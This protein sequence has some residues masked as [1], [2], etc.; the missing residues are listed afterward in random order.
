MVECRS[1]QSHPDWFLRDEEGRRIDDGGKGEGYVFM[2]PGQ[3]EWRRFFLRRLVET[4]ERGG[5][6][7]VLLDNVDASLA[8]YQ[9]RGALPARYPDD[10][11]FQTAVREFLRY[12][13][14]TYFFPEHRPL[15]A[16]IVANRD[17]E[18][19]FRYLEFLDG[20]MDESWAV[21]WTDAYRPVEEWE[22][23]LERAERIQALGK[24]AL[25]I[26]SGHKEDQQ[27]Q[28]FA[29]AS[30]LLIT[31][32]RAYFRYAHTDA[33]RELWFYPDYLLDPGPPLASRYREGEHWRRDFRRGSVLVDPATHQAT[34]QFP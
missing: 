22:A 6:T 30:Y 21:G 11:A 12:L 4:Q 18:V 20:A 23:H 7:G 2:D 3:P 32:G 8:R 27:R 25:L 5:F 34:L 1:A 9:Q 10:D 31:Y 26:A 14:E 19:W 17:F 16:N 24:Q 29:L 15:M 33:Y 28:R 13:Y